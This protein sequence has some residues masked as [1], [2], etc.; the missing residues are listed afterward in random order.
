MNQSISGQE[1][2]EVPEYS[3][4]G[5][6]AGWSR[7]AIAKL[8]KLGI[9]KGYPDGGFH[10]LQTMTRAEAIVSMDRMLAQLEQDYT[11]DKPGVY[12]F[13]DIQHALKWNIIVTV[14]GVT[15]RNVTVEGNIVLGGGVKESDGDDILIYVGYIGAFSDSASIDQRLMNLDDDGFVIFPE[16]EA[17]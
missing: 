12:D 13:S 17:L 14:P 16:K 15:L 1:E 4:A 9:M 5:L 2:T 3:D 7:A 8:E 6:I 10:P 11:I